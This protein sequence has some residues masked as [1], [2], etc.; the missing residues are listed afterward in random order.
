MM[1]PSCLIPGSEIG[2]FVGVN[3]LGGGSP[4][5][6]MCIGVEGGYSYWCPLSSNKKPVNIGSQ[7]KQ[8]TIQPESK[9]GFEHWKN[10]ESWYDSA[11]VW[12]VNND[13]IV[14]CADGERSNRRDGKVFN[15]VATSLI[16][17][18]FPGASNLADTAQ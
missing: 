4:H 5:Y 17:S 16:H 1:T 15:M 2:A 14:A 6:F 8:G 3:P 18:I 7:D 12:K 11:Q 10:K 13:R 9:L